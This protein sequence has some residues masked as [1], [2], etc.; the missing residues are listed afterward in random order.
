MSCD[1]LQ[2]KMTAAL[3]NVPFAA[4][5]GPAYRVLV[6]ERAGI[7]VEL[8]KLDRLEFLELDAR[9]LH[10]ERERR[11]FGIGFPIPTRVANDTRASPPRERRVAG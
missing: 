10:A 1:K 11:K 7:T 4:L 5:L 3:N 2:A 6:Y 8:A 9:A